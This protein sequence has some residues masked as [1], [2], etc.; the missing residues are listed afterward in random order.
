M[1]WGFRGRV[2]VRGWADPA[3]TST[4][5]YR[6]RRRVEREH[7]GRVRAGGGARGGGARGRRPR[8][9]LEARGRGVW[10]DRVRVAGV[11]EG[12]LVLL[13]ALVCLEDAGGR[14]EV[15]GIEVRLP[16]Q[17]QQLQHLVP[18]QIARPLLR[19][20]CLH[21][22]LE[23][24]SVDILDGSEAVAHEGVQ[25]GEGEHLNGRVPHSQPLLQGL[26]GVA[27]VDAVGVH[28]V[29]QRD[30]YPPVRIL[31]GLGGGRLHQLHGRDGHGGRRTGRG[32]RRKQEG[33][34]VG[35]ERRERREE[36]K[37]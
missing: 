10:R 26:H 28:S 6:S 37:K 19:R 4:H 7:R 23:A 22:L 3:Y 30:I 16:P 27:S 13:E 11:G 12:H 5:S 17:L 32:G 35:G 36:S 2:R 21:H 18:H 15:W 25:E 34:G 9:G 29:D 24:L 1:G 8:G 14:E 31:Q 20:E 33:D